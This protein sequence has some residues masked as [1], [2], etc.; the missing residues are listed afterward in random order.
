M[1]RPMIT[2]MLSL[3][4][5]A[6]NGGGSDSTT[7]ATSTAAAVTFPLA[8]ANANYITNGGRY[9]VT[10]SGNHGS[11]QITGTATSTL[12][13]VMPATFRGTPL[14]AVTTTITGELRTSIGEPTQLASTEVFYYN[15]SNYMLVAI[16][17]GPGTS[18]IVTSGFTSLPASVKVGDTGTIGT[19]D[20]Y[21]DNTLQTKT[22]TCQLLYVIEPKNDTTAILNDIK[23]CVDAKTSQKETTQT[24]FALDTT[25]TLKPLM[26]TIVGSEGMLTLTYQ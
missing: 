4:L 20:Q 18:Y 25:G 13:N 11:T 7:P 16:D 2:A 9:T 5:A 12:S 14:L 3:S 24:K 6:C 26:E 21:S 22:G 15:A 8:K 23:V 17:G 19:Y 1:L 10:I